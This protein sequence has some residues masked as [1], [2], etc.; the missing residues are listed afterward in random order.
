MEPNPSLPYYDRKSFVGGVLVQYNLD[1]RV[2][3]RHVYG[4]N[5][6]AAAV[7]GFMS[8]LRMVF[9]LIVPLMSVWSLEK[10]LVTK[11]FYRYKE[12]PED[13]QKMDSLKKMSY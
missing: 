10:Y 12:A 11:L 13:K 6:W 2:M 9:A 4:Y 7:G 3:E 1:K 8:S 5:E